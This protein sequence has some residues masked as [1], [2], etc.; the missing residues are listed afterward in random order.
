MVV[1]KMSNRAQGRQILENDA[2]QLENIITQ[3]KNEIDNI[4]ANVRCPQLA[5][6][7]IRF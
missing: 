4:N 1:D 6:I 7:D 2:E 3:L 5:H